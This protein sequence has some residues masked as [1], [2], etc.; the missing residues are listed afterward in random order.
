VFAPPSSLLASFP[1]AFDRRSQLFARDSLEPTCHEGAVEKLE[2]LVVVSPI[3]TPQNLGYAAVDAGKAEIDSADKM[4][5]NPRDRDALAPALVV[6]DRLDNRAQKRSSAARVS[7]FQ[8]VSARLSHRTAIQ[9][10]SS[11]AALSSSRSR[12]LSESIP[13]RHW[14]TRR[15]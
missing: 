7:A 12:P 8:R 1:E 2:R 14:W 9:M 11:N 3:E 15:P 10:K 4:S 13:Q 5:P 6:G